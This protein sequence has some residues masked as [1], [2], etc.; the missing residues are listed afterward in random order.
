MNKEKKNAIGSLIFHTALFLLYLAF[1]VGLGITQQNLGAAITLAS[2]L[3]AVE[4]ITMGG[5]VVGKLLGPHLAC[6]RAA[7]KALGEHGLKKVMNDPAAKAAY[8]GVYAMMEEDFPKAE[9]RLN[10]AMGLSGDV[11]QNQLF[12]IEWLIKLYEQINADEK[13]LWCYRKAVEFA[14]DNPDAQTRLGHAYYVDGRLDNALYCFEQAL[15]YDPNNGYALYSTA[16]IQ[17]IRGEDDKALET[18]NLLKKANES[19]PLVYEQLAIY[20]AMHG[21]SEKSMEAYQR[22]QLLGYREPEVLNQRI[23]ALLNFGKA[24]NVT[25]EDLPSEYY[26][27]I[28]KKETQAEED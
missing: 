15:R 21:D 18:L 4:I 12:C 27:R 17:M 20:Y 1:V 3:A 9:E 11:R 19:H 16:K 7:I 26:R 14:P 28:E 6:R 5:I 25:G 22:A 8:Q 2:M 24:E 10:L 23:T 13:L